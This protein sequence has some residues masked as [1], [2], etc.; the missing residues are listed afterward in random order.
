MA[1]ETVTTATTSTETPTTETTSTTTETTTETEGLDLGKGD[2]APA[3]DK[4]VEKTDE[5]KAADEAKALLF[6]APEVDA[7]YEITGLP[8][9]MEI[10]QTALEALTPVARELGLSNAGASKLAAI[11]AEQLPRVLDEHNANMTQQ[12]LDTRKAWEGE[13]VA[14]IK[15]ETKLVTKTG[16][17]ISFD[18]KS[19]KQVQA[20]AARAIDRLAPTGFREFLNETGIGQ[21]PAMVA[22]LYQA[23]KTLAED[24]NHEPSDAS[25]SSE[26]PV[27]KGR[28]G[29]LSTSKFYNR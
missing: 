6:G 16:D 13:S 20:D 26:G 1:D 12:I 19:I 28:S 9:G 5:E 10:D 2:D 18:G 7:A 8:E 15:G 14:A 25:K 11:Y 22:I 27:A 3:D 4:P 23:G 17:E 21:H 29:G 24:S